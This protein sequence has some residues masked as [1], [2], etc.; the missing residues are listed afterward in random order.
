LST[1]A[2]A[3]A[4]PER[5]LAAG[6]GI[7]VAGHD[8]GQGSSR[9]HAALAPLHLGVRAV[10]ARSYARAHRRNLIGVGISPLLL[11]EHGC[12]LALS[13]GEG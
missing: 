8:D 11:D 1:T 5:A 3:P 12:A 9:E 2:R 6:R 7:I 4:F 10:V 13:P